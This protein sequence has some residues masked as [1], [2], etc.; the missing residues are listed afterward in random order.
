M[1]LGPID[2]LEIPQQD[3]FT[4][5]AMPPSPPPID[6]AALARDLGI[7]RSGSK[8]DRVVPGWQGKAIYCLERYLSQVPVSHE[9]LAEEFVKY[10]TAAGLEEPPDGRAYGSVMQSAARRGLILKVGYRVALSSNLS[11]KTLWARQAVYPKI[12]EQMGEFGGGGE[13]AS[14]RSASGPPP[15]A[16][17]TADL[18]PV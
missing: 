5:M 1:S 11:P 10:A 7:L 15:V 18:E 2:P 6:Q 13:P 17:T 12:E 9:F 4:G 14:C 3:L 16:G 8:A